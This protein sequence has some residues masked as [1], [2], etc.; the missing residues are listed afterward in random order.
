MTDSTAPARRILAIDGGGLR[1]LIPACLLAG[2]E[3]AIAPTRDD[4]M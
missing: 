4:G 1:G 3:R 2:L